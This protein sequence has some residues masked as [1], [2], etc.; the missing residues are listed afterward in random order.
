MDEFV[1]GS[2]MFLYFSNGLIIIGYIYYLLMIL[3]GRS[4]VISKSDGF[5]VTKDIIS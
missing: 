3:L 5:D 4:K 1:F 2:Y